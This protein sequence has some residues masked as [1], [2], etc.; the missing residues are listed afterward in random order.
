[1]RGQGV[2]LHRLSSWF[3]NKDGRIILLVALILYFSSILYASF[4]T[5]YVRFWED[6]LKVSASKPLFL[7]THHLTAGLECTQ[8]GYDVLITNPCEENKLPMD[9]PRIWLVL[10]KLGL[11]RSHSTYIGI[12]I[13]LLF[14]ASI[15]LI[16]GKLSLFEGI[17]YSLIICSPS[18]MLGVETGN[19]DLLMFFVLTMAILLM[20]KYERYSMLG[21]TLFLFAAVLKLYPIAGLIACLKEE[22]HRATGIF[23]FFLGVFALYVYHILPDIFLIHQNA[24]KSSYISYGAK[25]LYDIVR[26]NL[27]GNGYD[28]PPFM[29][30]N[31]V[32]IVS[33]T[34][35]AYAAARRKN[36]NGLRVDHLDSFRVGAAIYII[37]YFFWNNWD[38]RFVFLI[39]TI[40]QI[41]LWVRQ[42]EILSGISRLALAVLTVTFWLSGQSPPGWNFAA[43]NQFV[44]DELLNLFLVGYFFSVLLLTLPDWLRACLFLTTK[45]SDTDRK[46]GFELQTAI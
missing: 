4:Y 29:I 26:L 27:I 35:I 16:A 15:F 23:V 34:A 14:L 46:S 45:E 32:L 24:A 20:R 2:Y 5:D 37:S 12:A 25:V 41:L 3:N 31:V 36:I 8:K 22:K 19:T 42:R 13:G 30:F 7:D 1:M 9:Y 43:P 10:S 28:W 6:N 18:I 39:F 21:Y 17:Q 40:P 44:V 11:N 38:Y 33:V